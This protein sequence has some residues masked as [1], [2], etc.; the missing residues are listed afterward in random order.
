[1]LGS[2]PPRP[3]QIAA[4]DEDGTV[5]R[6]G[7]GVWQGKQMPLA[8]PSG[9]GGKSRGCETCRRSAW[10][11]FPLG[12]KVGCESWQAAHEMPI[13]PACLGG[14]KLAMN[15]R[16]S[17]LA[18]IAEF[19]ARGALGEALFSARRNPQVVWQRVQGGLLAASGSRSAWAFA[20]RRQAVAW[21]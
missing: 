8:L 9:S 14:R 19:D 1:V 11:T 10:G 7:S 5:A 15:V 17:R 21:P 2:K 12:P 16:W 20:D 13:A 3:S 18:A 4:A 6:D